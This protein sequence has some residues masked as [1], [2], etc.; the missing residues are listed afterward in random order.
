[1]EQLVPDVGKAE[2]VGE[3][4]AAPAWLTPRQTATPILDGS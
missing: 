3:A 2:A 4:I 1:L